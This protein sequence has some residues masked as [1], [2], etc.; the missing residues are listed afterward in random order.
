MRNYHLGTH[1]HLSSFFCEAAGVASE[2]KL[3]TVVCAILIGNT[4][5]KSLGR[6]VVSGESRP[7]VLL[8]NPILFVC[9]G[10][11]SMVF[12]VDVSPL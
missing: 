8:E 12:F 11:Q 3:L 10:Q 5:A 4:L 9:F 6:L 2:Q 7:L 1:T